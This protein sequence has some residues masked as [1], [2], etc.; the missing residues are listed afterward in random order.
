LQ[1]FLKIATT[2]TG[3]WKVHVGTR[4]RQAT[5]LRARPFPR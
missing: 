3:A 5:L 1:I 2:L 4:Q